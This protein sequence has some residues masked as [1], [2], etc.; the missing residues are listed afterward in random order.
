LCRGGKTEIKIESI[1]AIGIKMGVTY[2]QKKG[3]INFG[4]EIYLIFFTTGTAKFYLY[5][6]NFTHCLVF[7]LGVD[8]AYKNR[9]S[10][11]L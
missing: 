10:L 6:T 3:N 1:S 2:L 11:Q 5:F 9:Y 8:N 7:E 4:F